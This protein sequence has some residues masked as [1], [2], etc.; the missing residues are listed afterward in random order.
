MQVRVGFPPGGVRRQAGRQRASR[1]HTVERVTDALRQRSQSLERP[2]DSALAAGRA[3]FPRQ[4][5]GQY[6][7]PRPFPR[8]IAVRLTMG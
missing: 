1:R 8:T 7:L 4:P 2:W 5:M 6:E 3:P